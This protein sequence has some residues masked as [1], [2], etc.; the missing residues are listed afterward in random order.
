V[1][2]APEQDAADFIRA[3]LRENC[4]GVNVLEYIPNPK[5]MTDTFS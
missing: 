4:P 2:S 1:L 5:T 3:R